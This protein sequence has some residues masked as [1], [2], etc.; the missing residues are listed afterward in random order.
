MTPRTALLV[1]ANGNQLE[2]ALPV[3]G[4]L[5]RRGVAAHLLSMDRVYGQGVDA[6]LAHAALPDGVTRGAI[7]VEPLAPPFGRLPLIG[8]L[9]A[10]TRSAPRLRDVA[11]PYGATVVGMDGAFERVLL[12][13]ARSAGRFTAMLWDGPTA[14]P[15]ELSRA[16]GAALWTLR[17]W[18]R[19][20]GR[21]AALRGARALGLD[22]YVPGLI[23]HTPV[24]RIY[25]MGAFV[26]RAFA[27]QGVG[28]R[29]ETTGLPRLAGA[30]R[31]R[32][33]GEPGRVLYVTG[34]FRWHDDPHLDA[35]QQRDLEALAAALPAAGWELCVRVHPREE[36]E[37][38]RELARRPGVSLSLP[39]AVPLREDLARAEVVVTTVSTAGL[40]AL[41]LGRPVIVHLGA[42]PKALAAL[43]L[44]EHPGIPLTRTP[45]A[46]LAELERQRRTR[47]PALPEE[48][49]SPTTPC[50]AE[51]V[52]SSI[53]LG[54][55][56][57]GL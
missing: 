3:A 15:P 24:D 23:G 13:R 34:A 6:A 17:R 39:A 49:C 30:A 41:A 37:P 45:D 2:N 14:R 27:E 44:A 20:H 48:F 46:L 21:R 5:A 53:E 28:S 55:A 40:E 1:C 54:L 25:T 51:L 33:A 7:P 26:T 18:L 56:R 36:P 52:A 50:A 42:F 10:V 47:D 57:T 12:R 32:S 43:T 4:A 11:T 16:R 9:A 38:Y 19:F 29:I 8:R 31:A 22:P 35:C